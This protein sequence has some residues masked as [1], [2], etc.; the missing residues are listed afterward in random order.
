MRCDGCGASGWH[1][2]VRLRDDR[3]RRGVL[4]TPCYE[5]LGGVSRF[6]IVCGAVNVAS[7]C[8]ACGFYVHPTEIAPET[9]RPGGG[10][11]RDIVSSG[12]CLSCAGTQVE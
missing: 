8:S 12:L 5:A 6:W 9:A 11:K 4:C 2:T 1:K 7:R 10:Y 3:E